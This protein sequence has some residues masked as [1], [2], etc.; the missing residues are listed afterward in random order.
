M[1]PESLRE[2]TS[3]IRVAPDPTIGG[4]EGPVIPG[5]GQLDFPVAGT[6]FAAH[7]PLYGTVLTSFA[8]TARLWA[9]CA[10]AESVALS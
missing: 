3:R 10:A 5:S 7:H 4:G 8:L 2:W 6:R 1:A 9:V